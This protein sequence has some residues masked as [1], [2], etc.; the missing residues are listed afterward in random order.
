[1]SVQNLEVGT[2]V[3]MDY[4]SFGVQGRRTRINPA[5]TW[6]MLVGRSGSGKTTFLQSHPGCLIINTDQ[7]PTPTNP[8]MGP[9]GVPRAAYYPFIDEQG[10]AVGPD[11]RPMIFG[12]EHALELKQR[13]LTAARDNA[14]RPQTIAID[15]LVTFQSMIIADQVAKLNKTTFRARDDVDYAGMY[16]ELVKFCS[17][18]H[19]HGY[20][21]I[22][23]AHIEDRYIPLGE[24][25]AREDIMLAG[26]TDKLYSRLKPRLSY[27]LAIERVVEAT[28]TTVDVPVPNHPGKTIKQSKT[29]S[30]PVTR[31]V[32]YSPA[33]SR[34]VKSRS[35]LPDTIEVSGANG[36]AEFAAAFASDPA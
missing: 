28:T 13:L 12:W 17:D 25:L 5:Y 31:I 21:V 26:V 19:S 29:V 3:T 27:L 32:N 1:M 6:M 2:T 14:P 23:T 36:W 24:N 16:D 9:S 11:G 4:G 15:S 30:R 7:S 18:L 20:G 22:L 34:I 8:D 10:R 35:S 33:L